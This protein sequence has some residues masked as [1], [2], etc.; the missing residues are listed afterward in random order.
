MKVLGGRQE[1]SDLAPKAPCRRGQS[2]RGSFVGVEAFRMSFQDEL[3]VDQWRKVE[4]GM[5][6][7]KKRKTQRTYFG[8][9]WPKA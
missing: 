1:R 7:D 5:S 9:K 4:D 2:E 8:N 3:D 6:K